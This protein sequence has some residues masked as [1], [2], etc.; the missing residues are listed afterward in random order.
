MQD[1]AREI[2]QFLVETPKS[3]AKK[4]EKHLEKTTRSYQKLCQDLSNDQDM[5]CGTDFYI[6]IS[7][8][9]HNAYK[10]QT[11]EA[12]WGSNS[13]HILARVFARGT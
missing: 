12:P 9:P 7:Q 6:I 4:L 10:A 5:N 13:V 11:S 3:C 1:S 2:L 8:Y